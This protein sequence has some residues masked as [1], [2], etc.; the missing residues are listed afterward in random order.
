MNKKGFTL[1]E[2]LVVVLIIGILAAIALPQ[3]RLVKEKTKFSEFMQYINSLYEAQQLYYLVNGK[4]SND[5]N[6]LDIVLP[7]KNCTK[8]S[9]EGKRLYYDCKGFYIGMADSY[10]NLQSGKKQNILYLVFLKNYS[11]A[12]VNFQEG[13]KYCWAYY[14]KPVAQKVCQSYGHKVGAASGGYTYYLID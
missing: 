5:I 3:Y 1:L 13:K 9:I 2:L 6:D 12:G 8:G 10:S 4:Y 7:I 11:A 14:N